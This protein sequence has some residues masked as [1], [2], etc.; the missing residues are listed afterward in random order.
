MFL[1]GYSSCHGYLTSL[2]L[3]P[4]F[5]TDVITSPQEVITCS[6]FSG[7][8]DDILS[9]VHYS[10]AFRLSGGIT[11][12]KRLLLI[13]ALIVEECKDGVSTKLFESCL[14]LVW[15]FEVKSNN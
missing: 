14:Y 11:E 7:A 3:S 1:G 10:G 8:E 12:K 5:S 9:L 15:P 2:R 13:H 4:L 6:F